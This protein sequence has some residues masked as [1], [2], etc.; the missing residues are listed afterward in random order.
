MTTLTSRHSERRTSLLESFLEEQQ[1][2]H[3]QPGGKDKWLA[4]NMLSISSDTRVYFLSQQLN[5]VSLE[6][7]KG[8][9]LTPRLF[10]WR[11]IALEACQEHKVTPSLLQHMRICACG[12]HARGRNSR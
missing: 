3:V 7:F 11:S 2:A 6:L 10:L 9:Q 4:V 5:A 8:V 12:H 1:P